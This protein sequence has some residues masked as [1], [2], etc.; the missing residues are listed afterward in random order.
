M[1]FFKQ[2]LPVM[3]GGYRSLIRCCYTAVVLNVSLYPHLHILLRLN[4]LSL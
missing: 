2:L 4:G 3:H 1:Y